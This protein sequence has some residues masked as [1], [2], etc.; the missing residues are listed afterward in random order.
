L[1]QDITTA[2]YGGVGG[3]DTP[4]P[5]IIKRGQEIRFL[6]NEDYTYVIAQVDVNAIPGDPTQVPPI[7]DRYTCHLYLD[8]PLATGLSNISSNIN[9]INR[10]YLI[11]EYQVDPSKLVIN[12]PKLVGG[13][14]GYLTP[15][16]MSPE[17]IASLDKTV[18]TLKENGIL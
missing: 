16:Y 10:G 9:N 3:Y 11:R 5:L 18:E 8:R 4:I 12:A 7:P 13:A 6:Q 1:A 17:L 14:P 2:S 15:Q